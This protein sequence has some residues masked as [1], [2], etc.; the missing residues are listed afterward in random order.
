MTDTDSDYDEERPYKLRNA[1]IQAVLDDAPLEN[2]ITAALATLDERDTTYLVYL[3]VTDVTDMLGALG[4]R[5]WPVD[6]EALARRVAVPPGIGPVLHDAYLA[7]QA[8]HDNPDWWPAWADARE[9]FDVPTAEQLL[10]DWV[11]GRIRRA[12]MAPEEHL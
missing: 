4:I 7:A 1:W 11:T 12:G 10:A 6:L 3:L 9:V 2:Q 8:D 5:D